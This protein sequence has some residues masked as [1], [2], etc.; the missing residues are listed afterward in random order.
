MVPPKVQSPASRPLRVVVVEKDEGAR[1]ALVHS[2]AQALGHAVVG[3]AADGQKM[4]D[5]VLQAEL[6]VVLFDIDLPQLDGLEALRRIGE[7]KEVAA[8][9]M[10]ADRNELLLRRA[11]QQRVLGYLLKPFDHEQLGPI[12]RVAQARFEELRDLAGECQRMKQLLQQRKLI[13]RAKG[14]L[15]QRHRWTE[16]EAFRR[17][18]RA[19]MNSRTSMAELSQ[20]I[21][22][23]DEVSL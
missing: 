4:I 7:Q 20:Q 10:T 23:G 1:Q 8:V 9:A 22:D 14:V 16:P 15:M 12:L 21:L 5:V 17:L 2:L 18:Q 3:Q 6:D 19:A 13:E 11:T